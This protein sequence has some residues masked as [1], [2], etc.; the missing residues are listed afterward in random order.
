MKL[1]RMSYGG[2][3]MR[4]FSECKI[5][6]DKIYSN[7]NSFESIVPV[8]LTLNK[9]C[10]IKNINGGKN[11]QYYKWQFIYALVNS[12]LYNKELIGT[13]VSFPK[14]NK[15][16]NPII[17]DI[18]IFDSVKWFEKYRDWHNRKDQSCLE[19]LRKHLLII[20]EVKKENSKNIEVVF[21]QQLKPEMKESESRYCLG[22]IY[23]EERLYIF[24]KQNEKYIRYDDSLN[25]KQEKSELKDLSLNIPDEYYK[26]PN[27]ESLLNSINYSEKDVSNRTVNDL[28]IVTGICSK[29]LTDGIN[30]IIRVMDKVSL[31][32]QRGYEILIEV[33]AMKIFDEKRSEKSQETLKFYK[34]KKEKKEIDLLF[35]ITNEERNFTSLNDPTIQSFIERMRKLYNEAS[36]K[37]TYILKK[38]DRET[39]SWTNESH[40]KILST[41]VEHFQ[42]YSFIRSH[43]TDLYQIVFYQ[44]ANEFSK[45][46]KGQFLTPIPIIDFIVKI[47]NPKR[48]ETIID[49]T[50]GIADFLSVSFANSNSTLDDNNIYGVDNDEQMI[51]L[52]QL[53]MLLNG[54]GNSVLKYMPDKGSLI[55]KFDERG[56]LVKLIPPLHKNGN[57]DE[58][59]DQTKLKKFDV[60]LTNP[61]FGENRKFECKTQADREV[62]ELYELWNTA[63]CGDWIDPGLLF[64]ENTVRI[65]K[66]NGRF[67]IVLS[68][69]I[70]SIDRWK[71]TRKWL[72]DN[73][74]IVALFDLPPNVFAETG[75]NTTIIVGYKPSKDELVKLKNINYEI[76]CKRIDKIGYEVRTSNKTK[77]FNKIYKYDDNTFELI[78]DEN[79]SAKIDEEFSQTVQDFRQWVNSQETTLVHLFKE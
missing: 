24:K 64:L 1:L 53:N 62:A 79:G 8:H 63:R 38:D 71:E 9:T 73:I 17:F 29:Q 47:V 30:E 58:W 68:N 74:R 49:P 34:T 6:F 55:W 56:N 69:S 33:L 77:Y 22:L 46:E 51:M 41:I 76:F 45:A 50:S 26:I 32:N 70:A 10:I 75:V 28:D 4:T 48:E 40:I 57:W 43:N 31:K 54:D 12:G 14:G 23:D 3:V 78:V 52:A 59:H 66:E 18:A 21:N 65:L 42:N 39:I 36:L 67:G 20:V 72:L 13:E 7:K 5:E 11:E 35:Y 44:F 19:W 27:L 37:Y 16:S 2:E 25:I 15:Q 60:V 61:P